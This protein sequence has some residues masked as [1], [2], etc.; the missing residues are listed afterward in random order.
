MRDGARGM[1]LYVVILA[2]ILGVLFFGGF[3]LGSSP[4]RLT[5]KEFRADLSE[6]RITSIEVEPI[7]I[8]SA[9]MGNATLLYGGISQ[10][11]EKTV[12]ISNIENFRKMMQEDYPDVPV[13]I[14]TIKPDS[15][16]SDILPIFI[17][18]AVM[19]VIMFFIWGS[20]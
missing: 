5:D 19:A 7:K 16:W 14:D 12:Y 17:M 20:P 9:E 11:A 15:I 2:V 6:G 13:M 4:E 18:T 8:G 3:G 10:T 1:L